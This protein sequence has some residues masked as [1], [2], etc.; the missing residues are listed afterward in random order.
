LRVYIFLCL[1]LLIPLFLLIHFNNP[2]LIKAFI[3]FSSFLILWILG[4][5]IVLQERE[6]PQNQ[7]AKLPQVNKNLSLSREEEEMLLKGIEELLSQKEL[8]LNPDLSL[9]DLVKAL[10][11]SRNEV[12][13]IIN[14]KMGKNFYL[15]INEYRVNRVK[16]LLL[17]EDHREM[18]ILEIALQ[19]GFNSKPGFNKV[20]KELTSQ[21]PSQYRKIT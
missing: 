13:W 17:S 8:F 7:P 20:F 9:D 16:E 11:F 12:S 18:T 14:R 21:T 6:K 5:K 10:G 15:L 3:S 4:L 1:T 2:Q 19:S